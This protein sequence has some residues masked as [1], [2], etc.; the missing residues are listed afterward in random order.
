MGKLLMVVVVICIISTLSA[1]SGSTK[2]NNATSTDSQTEQQSAT[3]VSS[4]N[5]NSIAQNGNVVVPNVTRININDAKQKL[6]ELNLIPAIEYVHYV[7]K[8][9]KR[10]NDYDNLEDDGLVLKQDISEGTICAPYSVIT[11]TVNSNTDEYMVEKHDGNNIIVK[12]VHAHCV[13][14]NVTIPTEYLGEK[15]YGITA[16]ALD[17]L[18]HRIGGRVIVPNSIMIIGN[19]TSKSIVLS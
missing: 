18:A 17:D 13:D 16:E 4:E 2:S 6:S 14:N 10:C 15:I 8:N 12:S 9:G 1:C 19:P 11:L 5:D 7:D 3:T